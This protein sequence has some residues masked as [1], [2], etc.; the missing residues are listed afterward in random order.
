MRIC[1]ISPDA[2]HDLDEI[3]DYLVSNNIEAGERFVISFEQKCA[4]Q[5]QFPKIGRSYQ[6]L[7]TSLRGVPLAHYIILYRLRDENIEIVRVV[8]GYRDLDNLFE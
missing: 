3:F 5:L 1:I 8:S 7:E 6:E 2:S 4:K